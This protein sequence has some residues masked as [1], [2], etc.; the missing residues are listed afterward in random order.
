MSSGSR[1]IPTAALALVLFVGVAGAR[2]SLRA[3]A[4]ASP[5]AK[6]WI[7]RRPAIEEYLRTADVVKL[8]KI[9][10]GVTGPRRAHMAPGGP[11]DMF[12]WKPIAPGRYKG[13]WESYKS[14]IAAYELDKLLALDMFPPAVERELEGELGAAVMWA[15][16]TKSFKQ[17]GGL[18]RPPPAQLDRWNRQIVRAKMID[19]LIANTDPNLGNWLVDPEWNIVL[20]DH[21]RAFTST[22]KMTHKMTRIDADLWARMEGLDQNVLATVLS[23]WLPT[24][25]IDSV[26]RRRDAMKTIIAALVAKRGEAAV[27]VRAP[28]PS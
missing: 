6:I 26:L 9:N 7:D 10:V 2:P 25:Q 16:P 11:V 19:N 13:Y 8:E 3:Q 1:K 22:L 21:S 27:F 15:S 28:G 14:E 23:S 4:P 24:D 20:I 12:T 17:L 5:G 18:P